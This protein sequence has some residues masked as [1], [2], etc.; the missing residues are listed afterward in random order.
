MCINARSWPGRHCFLQRPPPRSAGEEPHISHTHSNPSS[1]EDMSRW[2]PSLSAMIAAVSV[3]S[4]RFERP[5]SYERLEHRA[6]QRG[7]SLSSAGERLIDEG[8]RMEAHPGVVFRDGPS[9]RRAGLAAGP[10]I[11]EVVGLLRE[12]HGSRETRAAAAAAQLG[13]TVVQVHAAGGYYDEFASEI[14]AELAANEEAA[15]RELADWE[16]KLRPLPG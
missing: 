11:W 12:L 6:S 15:D 3:L 8:L 2:S 5:G 16:G 10:D 7:E 1:S 9:G 13:L 14:D 4:I